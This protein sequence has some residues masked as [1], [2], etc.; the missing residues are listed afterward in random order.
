MSRW[1]RNEG[2]D[3]V[4][5]PSIVPFDSP[6]RGI[7]VRRDF[8]WRGATGT[9]VWILYLATGIAF[10]C[11]LLFGY[12]G[13]CGGFITLFSRRRTTSWAPTALAHVTMDHAIYYQAHSHLHAWVVLR[14]DFIGLCSFDSNRVVSSPPLVYHHHGR[15]LVTRQ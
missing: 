10:L 14:R 11:S 8:F 5:F 2:S 12:V 7:S 4:W 3:S 15:T 1:Q 9:F 13:P 6:S